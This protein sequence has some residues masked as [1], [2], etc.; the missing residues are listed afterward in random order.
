MIFVSSDLNAAYLLNFNFFK[1]IK[2][3]YEYNEMKGVSK[4][5]G[6]L[7]T[8]K[9]NSNFQFLITWASFIIHFFQN[10]IL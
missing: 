4:W 5:E 7:G 3:Q 9:V 1:T 10:L 2:I 6:N 8:K